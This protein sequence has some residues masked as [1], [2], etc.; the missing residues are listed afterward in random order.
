MVTPQ[1]LRFPDL[2]SET[3]RKWIVCASGM[4]TETTAPRLPTGFT[5]SFKSRMVRAHGIRQHVVIG[6]AG[7]PVLL[8]HGWPENWYAGY[9]IGYALP[10]TTVRELTVW[11]S[12]SFPARHW[13]AKTAPKEMLEALGTF[14]APY[15]SA[16]QDP[17]AVES[18]NHRELPPHAA[19]AGGQA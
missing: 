14:L 8:V 9:L 18:H 16:Q 15:R 19:S 5:R 11:R 13:V 6:G 2:F 7:P 4:T 1:T 10:P 17:H 12:P 3:R